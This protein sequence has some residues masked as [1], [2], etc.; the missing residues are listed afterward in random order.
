MKNFRFITVFTFLCLFLLLVSPALAAPGDTTRVSVHSSGAEGN[1]A[2]YQSKIST[3]GDFIVFCSYAENLVDN[4]TN[5]RDDIFV[6]NITSGSTSRVSVSSTGTQADDSSLFP[7]IS[8]DGRIVVFAS[9]ASNLVSGDI[10]DMSDI[11]VHDRLNGT[12]NRVSVSSI[13]VQGNLHSIGPSISA[14]GR[15]VA[16]E[17]YSS[18]L[19]IGDTNGVSDVFVHDTS[20]GSTSLISVNSSNQQG[21]NH[22]RFPSISNDG[23]YVAFQSSANNL[24][25][26][27]TNGYN[28]IF[29]RDTT[30]GTTILVSGDALG[31]FGN[32][33]SYTPSISADGRFV[34]FSSI[35]RNLIV[36]DTNG[37][38]DIFVH[39]TTLGTTIQVS[40]DSSGLQ[41]NNSSYYPAISADGRYVAF[42]STADNLVAGD[43]NGAI[44]T[45]VHDT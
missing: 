6:H 45:F 37:V 17:S 40:K 22:S 29:V 26:N 31:T 41:G 21:N 25:A 16:F 35:A 43:T 10:N 34:A 12:T 24:V 36:G 8:A 27:D 7:S 32:G 38:E 33:N 30:T 14:D 39:D 18:D 3:N 23:R 5:G 20:T 42:H 2:S 44:D 13:G 15:Y 28:D 9:Y 11:F 4:D 1:N 19:V